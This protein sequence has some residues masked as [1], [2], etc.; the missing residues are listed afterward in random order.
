MN[1]TDLLFED[2]TPEREK[3]EGRKD[4]NLVLNCDGK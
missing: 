1:L 3:T 4:L 2:I